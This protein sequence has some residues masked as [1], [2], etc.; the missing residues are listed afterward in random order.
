MFP[1]LWKTFTVVPVTKKSRPASSDDFRKIIKTIIMT[2]AYRIGRAVEDAV[3]TLTN[4]LLC[5]LEEA[6]THA[7]VLYLDLSSAFNTLQSHFFVK[8]NIAL[9]TLIAPF[10]PCFI[11][12]VSRVF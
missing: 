8:E 1:T 2:F 9:L 5:H 10:C 4:Y 12:I 11:N 6:K 3:A 7:R